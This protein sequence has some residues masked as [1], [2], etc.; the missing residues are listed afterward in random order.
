MGSLRSRFPRAAA[1]LCRALFVL[2]LASGVARAQSATQGALVGSL[3][4]AS[5]AAIAGAT[6]Q[7]QSADSH[8]VLTLHSGADGRFAAPALDP[9]R[10]LVTLVTL[11]ASGKAK[12]PPVMIDVQVGRTTALPLLL[13]PRT[14]QSVTVVAQSHEDDAAT[15]D[16]NITPE[17]IAGLPVNLRR[18]NNFALLAESAAPDSAND[19][20]SFRALSGLLNYRTL[21][22][23]SNSPAFAAE[24]NPRSRAAFTVSQSAVREFQVNVANYSAQYGRAAGAVIDAVTQRGGERL[25][26]NVFFFDRDNSW[27]SRTPGIELYLPQPDGTLVPQQLP[28]D[29]RREGG[30]AV[31]GPVPGAAFHNRIFWH[32]TFDREDRDFPALSTITNSPETALSQALPSG[33]A[34]FNPVGQSC[35]VL[36]GQ[37]PNPETLKSTGSETDPALYGSQGACFLNLDDSTLYPNYAAAA[38][39][40]NNGLAYIYSL[41][42]PAPRSSVL[43]S[44]LP[45]VDFA[46]GQRNAMSV[47]W[48]SIR[49]TASAGGA[50]QPFVSDSVTSLGN[51]QL[52]LDDVSARLNTLVTTHLDNE[53]R[54][55][56]ARDYESES[57]QAPLPQEPHTALNG[58]AAPGVHISETLTLG[59]P[60]QLP[61]AEYPH[62]QRVQF[63]DALALQHGRHV[64]RAG[65]DFI[66]TADTI[67]ALNAEAGYF[68]YY[69]IQDLLIDEESQAAVPAKH[70]GMSGTAQS[71]CYSSYEQAF[72]SPSLSFSGNLYGLYA[73]DDWRVTPTFTLNLGLRYD[74]QQLPAPQAANPLLPAS[75]QFPSDKNNFAPRFGFAWKVPGAH[76]TVLRGGYGIFYGLTPA[77]TLFG[78]LANTGIVSAQSRG[79]AHYTFTESNLIDAPHYPMTLPAQPTSVCDPYVVRCPEPDVTVLAPH[80]QQP[81]VQQASLTVEHEFGTRTT[82]HATGIVSLARDLPIVVDENLPSLQ[83]TL[84][85]STVTYA[86][87]GGP[88]NGQ[89]TTVPFYGGPRPNNQF[90]SINTVES[91]VNATYSAL[92]FG[93]SHQTVG[94]LDLRAHYTYSHATDFGE[95]TSATA[96]HSE[97]LDPGNFA[98]ERG[99]SSLDRRSRLVASAVWETALGTGPHAVRATLSGWQISPVLL[100]A[101]GAPYSAGVVGTAPAQ[102]NSTGSQTIS[103]TSYGYLGAGG[104]EFLPLLGRNSFR[105]PFTQITDL[106]L[107][108]NL[109]LPGAPDR[110]KLRAGLEAF[111]LLNHRNVSSATADEPVNTIAYR[112]GSNQG[113]VGTAAQPALATWQP[114]FGQPISANATNLFTSRQLQFFARLIF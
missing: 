113:H 24:D 2:L 49:S 9:G 97:V 68:R 64:F 73:Q 93:I 13:S 84:L 20:I 82:I 31:G 106:R 92:T 86:F 107:S 100:V 12:L 38:A 45:R 104:A 76:S 1:V 112:I 22:G 17:E 55:G 99:A 8:A 36:T 56:Y 39:A 85:P 23:A 77:T 26:G 79:Q 19:D 52:A 101:S 44:N 30:I 94:H 67:A 66:H 90:G 109:P 103:P 98:E 7:V 96:T 108:R 41:L 71:P 42:G 60:S 70:C 6:L 74:Y 43:T 18:W 88:L 95:Q 61:R 89:T 35:A 57:A 111:N 46:L 81:S 63:A 62:E 59:T 29:W 83:N 32:Y 10:Y 110:L 91:R 48:N 53:L 80:F 3:A 4:D 54:A 87:S 72:G 14:L 28:S 50:T 21:D 16:T 40:Y 11:P 34:G 69:N 102:E 5:G 27:L 47:A 51:D 75:A 33:T 65:V 105:Q 37:F 15:V 114:N 58:A 25:H 78:A